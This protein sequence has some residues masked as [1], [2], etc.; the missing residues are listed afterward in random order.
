MKLNELKPR[1]KEKIHA[2][3]EAAIAD[4]LR[5]I[6]IERGVKFSQAVNFILKAGLDSVK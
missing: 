1:N 2:S 4:E 3:V 5:D 6:A